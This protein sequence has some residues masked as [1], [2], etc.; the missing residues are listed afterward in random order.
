MTALLYGRSRELGVVRAL[1]RASEQGHGGAILIRGQAG[2]GK[3]ALLTAVRDEVLRGGASTV[4]ETAGSQGEGQFAFAALHQLLR[5]LLG[6]LDELEPHDRDAMRSAFGLAVGDSP[7]LYQVALATLN[8]LGDE[9]GQRPVLMLIDDAHWLDS[10][11]ADVLS[12]V[13][14]RVGAE[15]IAV[16]AAARTD[17]ESRVVGA[18][19]HELDL[20][21]LE[22]HD[23]QL[24]LHENSE[25]LDDA[26]LARVLRDAAGNPL[27]LVELPRSV[28]TLLD[29]ASPIPDLLPLNTRLERAF[30]A[31]HQSLP[32]HTRILLLLAAADSSCDLDE[33]LHA[34]RVVAGTPQTREVVT[35]AVDA[36]L[37]SVLDR[38]VR[39]RH[40]LV[41]SGI[42]HAAALLDRLAAHAA[43]AQVIVGDSDRRSWHRAAATIGMDDEVSD[44]LV[45]LA[46]RSYTRGAIMVSVVALE[47]ASELA[48]QARRRNDLALRAAEQA[49]E[50]GRRQTA[51]VMMAKV[52]VHD[53]GIVGRARRLSI[54]EMT[55]PGD[56][57][58]DA[59]I[60]TLT[61]AARSLAGSDPE[62]AVHLL[63]RAA[64]R[65]WWAGMPH[66]QRRGIVEA[67]KLLDLASNDVRR[68]AIH[69]YAAPLQSRDIARQIRQMPEPAP[70]DEVSHRFLASTALILGDFAASS[71]HWSAVEDIYRRQGRMALL[72]RSLVAGSYGRLLTGEWQKVATAA[73]EGQLLAEE[74]GEAFWAAGGDANMSVHHAFRGDHALAETLSRRALAN[75]VARGVRFV[76]ICA[77]QGLAGAAMASGRHDEAYERLLACFDTSSPVH[78][79]D[80][81]LWIVDELAE[82]A[83]QADRA[84][85]AR[86]IVEQLRP[87]GLGSGQPRITVSFAVA[88]ALL[89]RR[90]DAEAAFNAAFALDLSDWPLD[91][92][93]LL[94]G[95]GRWLRR[96]RRPFE[97]R[98]VL[99]SAQERF[100][101][102]GATA[103]DDR[104]S[105]ELTAAG[106]E[107]LSKPGVHSLDLTPQELQI[108]TLAARGLTN[109]EIGQHLFLSHRTVGSHLYRIYPK[110]GITGRHE[111]ARAM[112][113]GGL[114]ASP[115]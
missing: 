45:G 29:S 112:G 1:V 3:T 86:T 14:R 92:A 59:R 93:R 63:W 41:A 10:S 91:A 51:A 60:D 70:D 46:E 2:M 68:L 13:A 76:L 78:H 69:A 30:A 98:D 67:L 66:E 19:L 100:V 23:A 96:E 113:R 71:R 7:D 17:E 11:S 58:D 110:L 95:Y 99:R 105:A 36:G 114:D 82:L 115:S 31:R 44:E 42:Y 22:D 52:D 56:L 15:S 90:A 37:I 88:D 18:G 40:P 16:V 47:R 24:L 26:T 81:Q 12:F 85:E 64:S 6:H 48:S 8:L 57:A 107:G 74:T 87:Q 54:L 108:A 28:G 75:P 50:L 27:A 33:L 101:A 89:A 39:F 80:M 77:Q 97:A 53:L 38:S 4:L 21:P 65:C 20:S 106:G 25:G 109:R 72:A 104:V 84:D 43:L 55:E 49:S 32:S 111:I 9:A 34:T 35:P 73:P 83:I 62:L 102:L 5:P 61:S 79:R 103:W 94:F